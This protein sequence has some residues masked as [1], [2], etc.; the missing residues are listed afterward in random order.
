ME[1]DFQI[2]K[3]FHFKL[4]KA[5]LIYT[6]NGEDRGNAFVTL[7]DVT[8][9]R[10]PVLGPAQT[11]TQD[12]LFDLASKMY[13]DVSVEILPE[14]ILAR[15]SDVLMWWTP[16]KTRPMFFGTRDESVL[17]SLSGKVFPHP[18]LVFVASGRCLA[19]RALRTSERPTERTKLYVAPYW[20][21]YPEGGVCLGSAPA[22]KVSN[23][24]AIKQWERA[25]FTS[26]FT[27]PNGS[28]KLT[29]HKGGF[30]GMW[31]SLPGRK[32]FPE[33]QLVDSKETLG[34]FLKRQRHAD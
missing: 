34:A 18:A 27:H 15:T 12:F 14:N 16:A 26:N 13:K 32:S 24:A 3:S 2:G 31:A 1:V 21:V 5:L 30:A 28:Q 19:V 9:E 4:H 8:G 6:G 7:H 29:N 22:P 20:N 25:F 17:A 23:V 33:R 10:P 11:L